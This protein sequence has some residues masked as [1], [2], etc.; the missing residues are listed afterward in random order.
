MK[1]HEGMK[2]GS[3]PGQLGQREGRMT[4]SLRQTEAGL[5]GLG[6]KQ[7]RHELA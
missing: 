5:L 4:G 1:K 3:R 6:L 7:F 2:G